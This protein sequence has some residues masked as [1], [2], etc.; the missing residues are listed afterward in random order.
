MNIVP[1][2]DFIISDPSGLASEKPK[3]KKTWTL[4][5]LRRA[6]ENLVS[7]KIKTQPADAVAAFLADMNR[8]AERVYPDWEGV[9]KAHIESTELEFLAKRSLFE[10]HNLFMYFYCGVVAIEG[11]K[12]R[13]LFDFA[14]ASELESE[15]NDQIDGVLGL[16]GRAAAD[17]VFD[18]LRTVKR[19]EVE[20]LVKPHD[21]I[22]KWIAR[23]LD[24][25]K[26]PET[27]DLLTD[28]MFCQETA[29]PFALA[30][31]H[32]W[33]TYKETYRVVMPKGM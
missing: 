21:Q 16:N 15:I 26:M 29:A 9:M 6:W 5:P 19:A 27:K 7:R 2:P 30:Q 18:M 33:L 14:L 3:L 31:V 8:L 32:W 10:E 24:L 1:D 17:L 11:I 25:D 13:T 22:M 28:F 12:V 20:D 23:L 4:Q